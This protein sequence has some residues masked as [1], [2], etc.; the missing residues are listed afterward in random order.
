MAS[1]EIEK[2]LSTGEAKKGEGNP[3]LQAQLEKAQH[4]AE[5]WAGRAKTQGEELKRLRES[6]RYTKGMY[7]WIGF[8]KKELLFDRG[9]RVAGKSA[10]SFRKLFGLAVDGITSFSIAPLR[11]TT[12]I[13]IIV[14]LLQLSQACFIWQYHLNKLACN[15]KAQ[16]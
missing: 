14:S 16:I 5:V 10:W 8:K 13:G 11:L 12:L 6:E 4:S 2:A 9:N 1:E 15:L 7:C 3:D